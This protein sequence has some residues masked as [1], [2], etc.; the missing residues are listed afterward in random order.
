MTDWI[1]HT[2][3]LWQWESQLILWL[4]SQPPLFVESMRWVSELGHPPA[5]LTLILI[6]YWGWKDE[7]G[8]QLAKFLTLC[9]LIMC[10][11]KDFILAPRPFWIH[12]D[13][14]ALGSA[15]GYG[16]PSGHAMMACVW[17]IVLVH[18]RHAGIKIWSIAVILSTGLSR[19]TLGVHSPL[20]V[21]AGWTIGCSILTW[22]RMNTSR[23]GAEKSH[24]SADLTREMVVL[25]LLGGMTWLVYQ[26]LID[27]TLPERW[28][29]MAAEKTD[30]TGSIPIPKPKSAIYY[31]SMSMGLAIWHRVRTACCDQTSMG[32]TMKQRIARVVTGLILGAG[33]YYVHKKSNISTEATPLV[34]YA[35]GAAVSF[36]S[37]FLLAL[38]FPL[39]FQSMGWTSQASHSER[40]C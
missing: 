25:T 38:G 31:L 15:G 36:V 12:P 23:P 30:G 34:L 3:K 16:M 40:S 9:G 8:I 11:M 2:H 33:T 13:V 24:K 32:G 10:L 7:A 28:L 39:L 26:R 27:W 14:Q 5:M 18:T 21:L 4:Q 37:S 17:L 1:Q 19:V 22:I 35:A 6:T 20:Q 29:R